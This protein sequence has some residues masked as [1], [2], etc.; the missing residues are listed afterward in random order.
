MTLRILTYGLRVGALLLGLVQLQCTWTPEVKTPIFANARGS[1]ALATSNNFRTPP[2]HPTILS[3]LILQKIFND[4]RLTQEGGILQELL[5]SPSSQP[6]PVFSQSQI[7]FLVPHLSLALSKATQEE[8]VDF[9]CPSQEPSETSIKGSLAIFHPHIIFLAIQTSK[10]S[11][12][13]PNKLASQRNSSR[14]ISS[15]S[16][17][18][19][20]DMVSSST[21]QTLVDLPQQA[22]W[23]A[24]DYGSQTFGQE[25]NPPSATSSENVPEQP[26]NPRNQQLEE[27]INQLREKIEA[28]TKELQRLEEA[29]P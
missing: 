13:A 21:V 17:L 4:L 19:P 7:D 28:Q 27:E 10:D 1:V 9:S 18:E 25:P 22:R 24:I 14:P 23:I 15:L 6:T 8:L 12:N 2:A 26:A 29:R 11:L 20:K 5:N 16:F 3:Q